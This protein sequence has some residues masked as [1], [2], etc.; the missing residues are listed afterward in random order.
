MPAT[1][2][3]HHA[4]P[5]ASVVPPAFCA[6]T[7]QKYVPAGR[8]LSADEVDVP[9]DTHDEPQALSLVVS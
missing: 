5:S 1:A 8:L 7:C 4:P 3:D 9:A 2:N 6:R